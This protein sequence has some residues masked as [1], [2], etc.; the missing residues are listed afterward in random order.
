LPK[1]LVQQLFCPMSQDTST[2]NIR[3]TFTVNGRPVHVETRVPDGPVRLDEM[4]PALRAI[5]DKLIDAAVA[6]HEAAGERISCR[7]GCSACCRTQPVPVTPPEAFALA[8][9]VDALPEPRRSAVRAAFAAAVERLRAAGLYD[10][11]M[12][13]DPDITREAAIAAVRRY[14]TLALACPFLVDDACSIHAQRPF[15]CRQYLVTSPPELCVAPLDNPVAP[16]KTPA[17]FATAMLK[18]AEAL[19]GRAQ[20]TVPLV[21]ALEQAE[22]NRDELARTHDAKAV[23]GKVME[24]LRGDAE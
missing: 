24:G 14:M 18:A 11:F 6:R 16:V 19:T 7:K 23:F 8:R 12:Q 5:D 20:Y 13:R 4:L 22:A 17:P 1:P 3:V 9:L 15:V 21:L 10:T 2:S